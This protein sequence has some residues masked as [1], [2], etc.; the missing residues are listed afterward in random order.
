MSKLVSISALCAGLLCVSLCGIAWS[1]AKPGESPEPMFLK[2]VGLGV[3][4]VG[5][6]LVGLF[7]KPPR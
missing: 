7:W 6:G 1:H 2:I 4:L 5:V 3:F